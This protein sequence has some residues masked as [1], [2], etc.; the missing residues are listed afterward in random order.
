LAIKLS[1]A[2][3][4][5]KGDKNFTKNLVKLTKESVNFKLGNE[6]TK[7]NKYGK[8]KKSIGKLIP[9]QVTGGS[10]NTEAGL[11]DCWEEDQRTM[12]K[13]LLVGSNKVNVYHTLPNQKKSKRKDV[14]SLKYSVQM[15]KPAAKKH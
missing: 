4:W 1:Y 10:T 13:E 15:N 7:Q 12:S 3:D 2:K 14:H 11:L 9:I 5:K 6:A 8:K